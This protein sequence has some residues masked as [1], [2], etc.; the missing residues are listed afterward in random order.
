[1]LLAMTELVIVAAALPR[2]VKP[3]LLPVAKI[4]SNVGEPAFVC[5]PV[6]EPVKLE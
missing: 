6:L 4:A 1:V 3:E 5:T 2:S